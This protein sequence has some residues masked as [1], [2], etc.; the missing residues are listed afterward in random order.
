MGGGPGIAVMVTGPNDTA[1]GV[2]IGGGPSGTRVPPSEV[3]ILGVLGV[4]SPIEV[5]WSP[6][7]FGT[8]RNGEALLATGSKICNRFTD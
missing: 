8:A 5:A 6:T 2:V 7:A 4:L 3:P 1:L